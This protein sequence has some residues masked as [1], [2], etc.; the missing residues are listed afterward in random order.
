[1]HVGPEVWVVPATV[2]H[3]AFWLRPNVMPTDRPAKDNTSGR[4][5]K[6]ESELLPTQQL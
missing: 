5:G 4:I 2:F 1:M 6:R 3:E